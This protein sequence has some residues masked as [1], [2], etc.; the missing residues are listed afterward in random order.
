MPTIWF[1]R[2]A[3]SQSDA[4]LQTEGPES[5]GLTSPGNK[6][7]FLISQVFVSKPD[8]IITSKYL[9][10]KL[11]AQPTIERFWPVCQKVWPV[12]EFT[13]LSSDHSSFKTMQERRLMVDDYWKRNNPHYKDSEEAESFIHF[14]NRTC[15]ILEI[16]RYHTEDF[17]VIFTHGQLMRAVMWLLLTKPTKIDADSMREF[18][19]LLEKTI[20]PN[21]SILPVKLFKTEEAQVG[22][23]ITSHLAEA[24][25][26]QILDNTQP[27]LRTGEYIA[28]SARSSLSGSQ[29][30]SAFQMLGAG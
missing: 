26:T 2:H 16:L 1:I 22:K 23:I 28:V 17:I 5:T 11:T 9:R 19:G 3:E 7:A 15:M 21:A 24:N 13:Y 29:V 8:L 20:M 27:K 12:H 30:F 4:G 18:R 10:S 25:E 14:M 6:Q